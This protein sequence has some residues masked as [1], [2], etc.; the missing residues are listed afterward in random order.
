MLKLT[1]QNS[2]NGK[3]DGKRIF[4]KSNDF[5]GTTTF[6]R[7][8]AA[9][10]HCSSLSV[11]LG[12]KPGKSANYSKRNNRHDRY[13]ST[14]HVEK[15][16]ATLRPNAMFVATKKSRCPH[17][18]TPCAVVDASCKNPQ[19]S[20]CNPHPILSFFPRGASL[21]MV[22]AVVVRLSLVLLEH[23]ISVSS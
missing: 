14:S 13:V 5:S 3:K 16:V 1:Q 19:T 15:K 9:G 23:K 20:F 22:V 4:S 18:F 11:W 17:P 7:D 2:Q 8:A 10:K 21:F 6:G 12:L